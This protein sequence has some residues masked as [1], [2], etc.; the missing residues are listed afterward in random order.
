[1][2]ARVPCAGIADAG[3][4]AEARAKTAA[5]AMANRSFFIVMTFVSLTIVA[6]QQQMNVE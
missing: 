6:S 3:V 5:P 1:V 4:L 2:L